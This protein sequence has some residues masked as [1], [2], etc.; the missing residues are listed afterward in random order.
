MNI[1]GLDAVRAIGAGLV[2]AVLVPVRVVRIGAALSSVGVLAAYLVDT[3][4]GL[5]ATRLATMFTLPVVV[6][7]V[8]WRRWL[9]VLSVGVALAIWQPPVLVGDLRDAGNPTADPQYFAPLLAELAS[10]GPVGRVEIPPTRNYWEAAYAARAVPLARGWLR[11]VDMARNGLFFDGRLDAPRYEAWLRDNGV[12][13]VALP[14]APL[15]WVGAP[16]AALIRA[17]LPYLTAV[18]SNAHWTLYQVAGR[19]S[20]VAGAALVSSDGA[21]VTFEA[22]VPGPVLVRVAPSR[23]LRVHGPASAP[24][25]R[26]G[27]WIEL[28]VSRPGRY[29][30]TSR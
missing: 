18:W 27:R 4:V 24:I 15:S 22:A 3:P 17:G 5:N 13:H 2:V 28:R 26:S 6:A 11:Q 20:V 12:S 21:A 19:P 14:D 23:W 1:S 8:P 10:R 30:V 25:S 29:T 16:E 9:A 7:C